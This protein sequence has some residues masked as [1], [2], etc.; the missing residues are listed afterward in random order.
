MTNEQYKK[1]VRKHAPSSPVVT[2]TAKAFFVGGLICSLGQA[3]LYLY[4]YVGLEKTIASALAS[5]SLVLISV[6]LT[7][8]DIYD[9]IARHG[10]AGTLVPITGFAN[11]VV[12]PAID[13]KAEGYV[14]GL[15]AKLF[16]IAGP[17]ILYGT[18]SSVIYG[19]VIV[20]IK[21]LKGG[22]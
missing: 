18:L 15:G 7:A 3:F 14:L 13:N 21:M 8:C 9:A 10:G 22:M 4:T 1:Y 11:A 20:V 17:V 16:T 19:V 5:V 12:S 2:N 6:I